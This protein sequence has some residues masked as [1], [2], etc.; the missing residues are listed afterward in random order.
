[1]PWYCVTKLRPR[2]RDIGG[3]K[4]REKEFIAHSELGEWAP[5]WVGC[6][7]DAAAS[8]KLRK[9]W[10]EHPDAQMSRSLSLIYSFWITHVVAGLVNA[11]SALLYF[12]IRSVASSSRF[13]DFR[14]SI[15]LRSFC[16]SR[17]Q[18]PGSSS[19]WLSVS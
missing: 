11:S 15:S 17:K 5:Q 16:G 18:L 8:A 13:L 3:R 2:L 4:L 14:R 10:K 9:S 12:G 1:M 7:V 6:E 19:S